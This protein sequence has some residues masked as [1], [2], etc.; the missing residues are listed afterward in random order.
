MFIYEGIAFISDIVD[1]MSDLVDD[2]SDLIDDASDLA[3][4]L[5]D[6][7]SDLASDLV[8]GASD[9]VDDASDVVEKL[10]AEVPGAVD[11]VVD[12]LRI[13]LQADEVCDIACPLLLLAA[14]HAELFPLCSIGCGL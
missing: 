5:V 14:G 4:D 9:I 6:D 12:V 2:A 8:D 3:S 13:G 7:V 10:I 1:K 11:I